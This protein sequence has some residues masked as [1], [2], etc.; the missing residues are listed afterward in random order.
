MRLYLRVNQALWKRL[1][2]ALRETRAA[3]WYGGIL[4][5]MVCRHARREQYF[6]T[7][8]LR[9]R[10]VLEQ[11]RRLVQARPQGATVRIA[12]LGCSS[13]AEV[14]SVLWAVRSARPDL[15][16]QT[17]ALDISAEI[18]ERGRRAVYTSGSSE[19]LD[20]SIFERLTDS[21]LREMFDWDGERA[22]VKPWLRAGIT[23]RVAD[24][25]DPAL[26]GLLGSQDIVVASNFL[27]HMKPAAAEGCLRNIARLVAEGGCVFV[28]GVDLAVRLKVARELGWQPV[29]ELIRE[30][31]DGDPSLRN[32]WPWNWWGLEPFNDRRRDWQLRYAVA[33]R[34]GDG[35]V[36]P[37]A[38][39]AAPRASDRS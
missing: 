5:Q 26:P 34:V 14:Y 28:V 29:V 2:T 17:E 6:G 8:F 21:E 19:L 27:C 31:H 12:V 4:H 18:L 30:M 10:P 9:N 23:W 22:T 36:T 3:G 24:A 11:V 37:T 25:A 20:R 13:G 35:A 1:P 16:V 7:F 33:Y 32:D 15:D 38:G 39:E